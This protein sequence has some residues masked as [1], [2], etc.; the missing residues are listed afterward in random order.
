[1]NRQLQKAGMSTLYTQCE[2]FAAF[3]QSLVA[4]CYLPPDEVITGIEEL[5]DFEFDESDLSKEDFEKAL[6]YKAS[7]LVYVRSQWLNG[8]FHPEVCNTRATTALTSITF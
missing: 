2:S 8:D 7:S 6:K 1:M 5:E 4:L 3:V